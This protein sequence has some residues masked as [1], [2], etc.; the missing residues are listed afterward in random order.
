[1]DEHEQDAELLQE[2]AEFDCEV[3]NDIKLEI[4]IEVNKLK[5]QYCGKNDGTELITD[6]ETQQ[7]VFVC[8]Y[9]LK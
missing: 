4:E 6:G 1:M 2:Q 3:Y 7:E 8:S 5:C 9:C